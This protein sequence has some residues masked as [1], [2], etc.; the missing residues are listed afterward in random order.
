MRRLH[1]KGV[2]PAKMA[3]G[4]QTKE[5]TQRSDAIRAFQQK[6]ESGVDVSTG[7]LKRSEVVHQTYGKGPPRAEAEGPTQR[8]MAMQA[9]QGSLVSDGGAH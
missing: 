1:G 3:F 6:A 7:H 8:Q 2:V 9:L 4:T 5:G